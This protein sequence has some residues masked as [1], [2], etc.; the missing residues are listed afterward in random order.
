MRN[1]LIMGS[2]RS[3]TSMVAGVLRHAGYFMGEKLYSED[4]G[5]PKGYFE[6][7]EVNEINEELLAQ[8]LPARPPGIFG[9]MFF[10]SRPVHGQRWLA[11]VPVGTLIPCPSHLVEQIRALTEREPFCFKDPRFCYTLPA[12]RPLLRN[13]EF[14]CIFRH[15]AA[16]AR[17]ILKE[18]CRE[19]Y[20]RSVFMNF[21]RSLEVWELMYRHILEIHCHQGEWLF[22]HYNQFL[23][24]SAFER[25]EKALGVAPDQSFPDPR[26]QRSMPKGL[27][28]PT[29][30]SLYS[31]LCN[32]AGYNEEL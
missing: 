23:N 17:S 11:R 14:I 30:L 21:Q 1:C 29:T 28:P 20:L 8:V 18:R 22:F 12:W 25:I 19:P 6:D 13:T 7:Q 24:G 5:N 26:L 9:N 2:G 15:P 16:T 31:K 32:L 4:E 10:R 27:V 3:G